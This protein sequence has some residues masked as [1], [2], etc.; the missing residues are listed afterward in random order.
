MRR[1][2]AT[3]S[4]T[5]R[6]PADRPSTSGC[7]R[8]S[9]DRSSC[10][11]G[12]PTSGSCSCPTCCPPRGRRSSTPTSPTG[13]RSRPR[14]RPD[15]ADVGAHRAAPGR[16]KV[17]GIDLV[18][19]RLAMAAPPRRRR[20]STCDESTTSAASSGTAPSGRGPDAVIDA[21][22]MEA[23]GSPVAKAAQTARRAAAR[24]G[25]RAKLMQNVGVDRLAALHHRHRRG[26][27][28]RHDLDQRRVRRHGRPAADAA[29]VRQAAHACG[30][31]RPTS[32]AGSTTS[33]RCSPTSDPLGVHDLVTHQLP[34]AEAPAAYE[35]FQKKDDGA[36]KVVFKP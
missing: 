31:A 13:G 18:A 35:M 23:H 24:R 25:R 22:G 6:C 1:C 9:T 19:E 4:S 14:P 27:P 16:G 28:R 3:R 32:A 30:W 8:R 11:R 20:P 15:R 7:P 21:V 26:A 12:R 29:D 2:S 5:A 17:F 36:V 10:P 34:L 33:C